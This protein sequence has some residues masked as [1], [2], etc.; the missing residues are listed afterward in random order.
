M[1]NAVRL[2]AWD[3]RSK[4]WIYGWGRGHGI[5]S[6]VT[7]SWDIYVTVA[8]ENHA[9]IFEASCL[10]ERI[11]IIRSTGL[12]DK[13]GVEVW[14]GDIIETI[15]GTYNVI[16]VWRKCWAL[17]CLQYDTSKSVYNAI[18]LVERC[19]VVGNNFENP[20]LLGRR[21]KGDEKGT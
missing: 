7:P 8:G 18:V 14:E 16:V 19:R 2:K 9:E 5:E 15:D 1:G 20:E 10:D 21:L 13:N 17:F 3:T 12:T 6:N 11:I 4:A